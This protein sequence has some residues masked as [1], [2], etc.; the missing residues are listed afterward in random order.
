M[1]RSCITWHGAQSVTLPH[2]LMAQTVLLLIETATDGNH[3]GYNN[4]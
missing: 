4:E 3:K 1:D 2:G